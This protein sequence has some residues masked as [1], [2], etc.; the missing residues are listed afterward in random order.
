MKLSTLFQTAP[1]SA[2]VKP[3]RPTRADRKAVARYERM[4]RDAP[5]S[6]IEQAHIAAFEKLTPVQLDLLFERFSAEVIATS[7]RPADASP[8]ALGRSAAHAEAREP[9]TLR[10]VLAPAPAGDLVALWT[11]ST[12][13]D[14]V[15]ALTVEGLVWSGEKFDLGGDIAGWDDWF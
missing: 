6:A 13:F 7:D 5:L 11:Y 12:I 1:K 10:R 2:A 4:L 14:T 3:P 8:T 15:A 9:G